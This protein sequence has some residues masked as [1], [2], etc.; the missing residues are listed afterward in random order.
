VR[1]DNTGCV[2]RK[3]ADHRLMVSDADMA[4]RLQRGM[5]RDQREATAQEWRCGVSDDDLL[6]ELVVWVLERGLQVICRWIPSIT[7][8]Y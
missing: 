4:G 7:P 2:Q 3:A 8:C 5:T 6:G 1:R